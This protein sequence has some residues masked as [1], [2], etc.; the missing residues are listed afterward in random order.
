MK[1]NKLLSFVTL[2]ATTTLLVACQSKS[3]DTSKT[4]KTTITTSKSTKKEGM[5]KERK[6]RLA[7]KFY[8]ELPDVIASDYYNK[9]EDQSEKAWNENQPNIFSGQASLE[10]H[11]EYLSEEFRK[12]KV[13]ID[14]Y[15]TTTRRLKITVKN[16]YDTTL[17]GATKNA[18]DNYQSGINFEL[19]G[20]STSTGRAEKL[21][22]LTI[23]LIEDLEAG[24]SIQLEVL[25]KG[26]LYRET[27]YAKGLHNTD[28]DSKYLLGPSDLGE[29]LWDTTPDQ[30]MGEEI[31]ADGMEL[32]SLA[33]I[34]V[35]PHLIFEELPSDM[36]TDSELVEKLSDYNV[37]TY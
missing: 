2:L 22:I 3:E 15:D 14:G 29:S 11:D 20:Y 32:S 16:N 28:L 35:V 17:K 24:D 34:F 4:T 13:T 33:N 18:D 37:S 9:I 30:V 25:P 7:K 6:E 10:V 23:T 8:E 31:L 26:L 19:Y 1:T 21:H 27:E 36:P 5:S 12:L